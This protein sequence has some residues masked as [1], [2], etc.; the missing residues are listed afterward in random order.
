MTIYK[1]VY[2]IKM[3]QD[4]Q[5]LMVRLSNIEYFCDQ[6]AKQI[7]A[8]LNFAANLKQAISKHLHYG[9]L[10]GIKWSFMFSKKYFQD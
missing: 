10:H 1:P 4:M 7:P 5:E 9:I 8:V 2:F 3:I 6:T